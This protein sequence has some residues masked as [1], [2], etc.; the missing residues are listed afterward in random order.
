V[1]ISLLGQVFVLLSARE[2]AGLEQFRPNLKCI[3]GDL[4]C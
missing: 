3:A 4:S 2:D 1:C